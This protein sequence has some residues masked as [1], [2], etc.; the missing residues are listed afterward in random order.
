MTHLAVPIVGMEMGL[1][2]MA[3]SVVLKFALVVL[4]A[5][6]AIHAQRR[7]GFEPRPKEAYGLVVVCWVNRLSSCVYNGSRWVSAKT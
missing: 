3:V 7:G 5:A 4:L 1:A 6:L 2:A